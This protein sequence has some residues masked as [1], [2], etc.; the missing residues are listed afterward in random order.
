MA[1]G[2]LPLYGAS[3]YHLGIDIGA[4]SGTALVA[5][6]SGNIS[7]T[8]FKG[9]N[10]YMI[11]LISNEYII[12]YCH[13]SPT[14]LVSVGNSVRKGDIIGYVGPKNVYGI[15]NNPYKDKNG[16]PT[17]GVTTGPHL[18]LG[19]KKNGTAIDPLSLFE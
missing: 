9:A 7:F 1:K 4:P 2:I 13:V 14:I 11:T 19:I 6:C 10:G 8:G 17:N 16:N 12:S 3:S 15:T 18:H 5:L